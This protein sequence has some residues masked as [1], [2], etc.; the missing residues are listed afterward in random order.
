MKKNL[1]NCI[2]FTVLSVSHFLPCTAQKV[3]VTYDDDTI[4]VNGTPYALMYK[5]SAGALIYDFSIRNITGTELFFIK[6]L[7][8]DTYGRTPSFAYGKNQ[9]VYHEIN[10]IGSGGRAELQHQSAK[11]FA[12]MIVD[13][14]LIKDNTVDAEAEKRFM[15]VYRGHYPETYSP[16]PSNAP[17]VNVNINNNAGA[18][19]VA[20][21]A[22][23]PPTL[24]KSKSPVTL[25][26]N[27]ILRDNAVIGKFRQDTSTSTYSEKQ[28]VITV[29]SEGGEKV[30]E[31]SAP[32][33]SQKEWNIKTFSDSKSFTL[34]YDSP[35]ERE[36]L[37]RYLAD[38]NYL[39]P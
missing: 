22:S 4:K 6:V 18:A 16:P 27:Q 13:N 21:P 37:F 11:G 30:A 32:M 29:Y 34:M 35:S 12:K 1:R 10:F 14:N 8:R 2:L 31:A 3:K 7:L 33:A 20:E 28:L 17:V 23:P 5:K 15:Q 9:E 24:P 25:D 38:K 36:K 39:V 19:P 26:G